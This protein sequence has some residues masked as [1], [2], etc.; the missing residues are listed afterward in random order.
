MLKR[1][2]HVTWTPRFGDRQ[3]LEAVV[4]EL[5]LLDDPGR[6][7]KKGTRIPRAAWRLIR[8][9]W[10]VLTVTPLGQGVPTGSFW[11][12]GRDVSPL[13]IDQ[14]GSARRPRVLVDSVET[15]E[16]LIRTEMGREE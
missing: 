6:A 3:R 2:D 13:P 14:D 16:S 7:S 15:V 4:M 11:A 9:G 5:T 8:K 12:Y 10:V 1:L